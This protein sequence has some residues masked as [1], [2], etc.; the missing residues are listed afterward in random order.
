MRLRISDAAR[1]DLRE[2][3]TYGAETFGQRAANA[4]IEALTLAIE[5]IPDWP[6]ASRLRTEVRPPVRLLPHEGHNIFYDVTSD[7]VV[8]VRVL[9][10]TADWINLL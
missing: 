5:K 10:Y 1:A 3:H 2:L 8:V 4:Y 6:F 7:E 9:H